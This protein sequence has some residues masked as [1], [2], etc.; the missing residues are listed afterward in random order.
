LI[1]KLFRQ[2]SPIGKSRRKPFFRPHQT[3]RKE[4]HI[5]LHLYLVHTKRVFKKINF[6]LFFLTYLD[7]APKKKTLSVAGKGEKLFCSSSPL[8]GKREVSEICIQIVPSSF[9][10]LFPFFPL[11]FNAKSQRTQK[12]F[13]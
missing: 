8:G 9:P 11:L 10:L 7:A 13:H 3:T 2:I 1:E 4:A 12:D 5:I 6:K